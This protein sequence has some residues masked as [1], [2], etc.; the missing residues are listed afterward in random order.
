MGS[1]R[2]I[3]HAGQQFEG[4]GARGGAVVGVARLR[5][6]GGAEKSALARGDMRA[7][8]ERLGRLHRAGRL[9]ETSYYRS[10]A[11]S[12]SS[13]VECKDYGLY[14]PGEPL[15]GLSGEFAVWLQ[16]V[17]R[18][19]KDEDEGGEGRAL[20]QVVIDQLLSDTYL[21]RLLS[22]HGEDVSVMLRILADT[23]RRP[24]SWPS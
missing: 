11:R 6:D 14:E 13:C 8:V 18:P 21:E 5:D 15:H 23:G 4:G 12:A 1:Q 10:V 19:P 22:R 17:R 9:P 2:R 24:A 16:D 7:F 20:P 3:K